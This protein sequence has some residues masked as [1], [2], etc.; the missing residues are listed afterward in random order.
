MEKNLKWDKEYATNYLQEVR[1]LEGN[2]IRPTFIREENGLKTFKFEK[3]PQL[4][5]LLEI[6]YAQK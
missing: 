3:T 6:F 4:F 1:F 2:N 5:K